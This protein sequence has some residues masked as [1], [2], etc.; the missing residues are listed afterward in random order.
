M[1]RRDGSL[2]G[3]ACPRWPDWPFYQRGKEVFSRLVFVR[4]RSR[5]KLRLLDTGR[6]REFRGS[7]EFPSLSASSSTLRSQTCS[8]GTSV[9]SSM[10]PLN[11]SSASTSGCGTGF[12][13]AV[14]GVPKIHITLAAN[15]RTTALKLS[16]SSLSGAISCCTTGSEL[17]TSLV[18]CPN[19]AAAP[20]Q[21]RARAAPST[22]FDTQ[23][24]CHNHLAN[25]TKHC[26]CSVGNCFD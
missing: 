20:R 2:L 17:A 23:K 6:K 25:Q 3:G 18:E 19:K 4:H 26:L 12:T 13:P 5:R 11:S 14:I 7:T 9:N 15:L 16:N 21:I 1:W 24:G 10:T 22:C 8:L